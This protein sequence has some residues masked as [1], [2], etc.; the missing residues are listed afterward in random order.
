MEEIKLSQIEDYE[1]TDEQVKTKTEYIGNL[2][3]SSSK[4]KLEWIKIDD[5]ST[6]KQ[7]EQN[8][9]IYSLFK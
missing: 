6:I 4:G 2:C 5:L 1:L 7:L 9:K 8:E 3:L